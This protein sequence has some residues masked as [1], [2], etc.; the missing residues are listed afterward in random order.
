MNCQRA[1]SVTMYIG[2][3]VLF[4]AGCPSAA[5][6][7]NARIL[8]PGQSRVGVSVKPSINSMS[9]P[10]E[11]GVSSEPL[12]YA[13]PGVVPEMSY[14]VGVAENVEVGGRVAPGALYAELDTKLRLIGSDDDQLHFA[15]QPAVGVQ[16]LM[17]AI[18]A[19]A[20][21]P[22]IMTYEFNDLLALSGWGYGRYYHMRPVIGGG[23]DAIMNSVGAGVGLGLEVHGDSFYFMPALD[24]SSTF[25][26]AGNSFDN[27]MRNDALMVGL[28][29]GWHGDLLRDIWE[30]VK[31][32]DGKVDKVDQKVDQVDEKVDR[33][34]E[35]VDE[36]FGRIEGKLDKLVDDQG[37]STTPADEASKGDAPAEEAAR[38]EARAD[39]FDSYATH[40]S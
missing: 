21:L 33:L 35:K 39:P 14:H 5:V 40:A 18:G 22:A 7:R 17:F 13:L 3:L 26:F 28:S 4:T 10:S 31:G 29:F 16:P 11:G 34:E 27:Y 20:T 19:Q 2:S 8:D 24:A 37:E 32:I 1:L 15:L 30:T 12:N 25:T 36:G 23:S 9:A 38:S 6:Y